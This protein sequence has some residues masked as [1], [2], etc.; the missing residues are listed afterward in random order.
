MIDATF[1]EASQPEES[2]ASQ[3][4]QKTTDS[5]TLVKHATDQSPIFYRQENKRPFVAKHLDIENVYPSLPEDVK[6]H[7]EA[8]DEYFES[9]VKA[10]KYDNDIAAYK[11]FFRDLE[12]KTDTRYSPMSVKLSAMDDF[13]S[14]LIKRKSYGE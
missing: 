11:A 9:Q 10:G 6:D 7:A 14:Y 3:T 1:R 5:P 13:I 2:S 4:V 8:V 12:K